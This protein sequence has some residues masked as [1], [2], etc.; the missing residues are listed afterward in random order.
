MLQQPWLPPL[1][2]EGL[3]RLHRRANAE[4]QC[5]PDLLSEFG[6]DCSLLPSAMKLQAAGDGARIFVCV[7]VCTV[8]R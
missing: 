5:A 1:S 2:Q 8:F 3:A 4:S 7:C 6:K